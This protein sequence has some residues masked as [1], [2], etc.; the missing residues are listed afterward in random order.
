MPTPLTQNQLDQLQS[1]AN[2]DDYNDYYLTLA[3]YGYAYGQL[4]WGVA[5]GQTPEGELARCFFQ[6][7]AASVGVSI[8]AATWQQIEIQL[9]KE[10]IAAREANLGSDLS[11]QQIQEYH[12]AVFDSIHVPITAWMAYAPLQL[13]GYSYWNTILS[14][15]NFWTD[16]DIGVRMYAVALSTVDQG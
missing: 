16:T 7:T 15:N 3:S 14:A 11:P 12:A 9:M 4:A 5:A 1:L 2:Q 10:D 6:D 13:F 8:D